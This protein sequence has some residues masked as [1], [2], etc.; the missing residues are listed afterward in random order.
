MGMSEWKNAL[1]GEIITLKRGYDL[2]KQKR[3][4]GDVPIISS[5]GVTASH[6]SYKVKGPGVITGRYGT[7]GQVYYVENDYWPL[8][9]TLYVEDFKGNNPRFISYFLTMLDFQSFSAKTAV[10]GINRNDLHLAKVR[11]PDI[12]IQGKITQIILNYDNLIE[13]NN[14]RIA[15]LEQMAQKLYCEWFVYF[16]FPG[17]EKVK[18]VE[19]E[20]GFIPEGWEVKLTGEILDYSRGKSYTSKEL[21]NEDGLPLVNLKNIHA[22]GG[23]RED[24]IKKFS[25]KYKDSHVVKNGDIILAITDMT[26]ERRLAGQVARVANIKGDKAIITMD[27]IRINSLNKEHKDFIYSMFRFTIISKQLAEYANGANVLHLNPEIVK[28]QKIVYPTNDLA[29]KFN[30]MVSQIYSAIDTCMAKNTN[31]RKTRDLLLPRLISGDIDVSEID[32]PIRAV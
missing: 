22:Y 3:N 32:I 7:I 19:S 10:P 31:L 15:I 28:Q 24:G 5:S 23:F 1:L 30:N 2:P 8:N 4:I 26:Q 27:L 16:R 13:C 25:G 29:T 12:E 14:R 9:T 17:H 20:L 18:I 21:E 6:D 11:I